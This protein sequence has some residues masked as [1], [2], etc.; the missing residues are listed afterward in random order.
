MFQKRILI[1]ED[2]V[3]IREMLRM[4]LKKEGFEVLEA[5]DGAVGW[6]KAAAEKPD[7]IL[8]DLMLPIMSGL[9]M[10]RKLR[11]HPPTAQLPALIVSARGE[12]SDV[13]VGLELGAD[14]YVTKPFNMSV[15]VARIN[16]L[17]RRSYAV[18]A[19]TSDSLQWGPLE[20]D[21][22]RFQVALD[23]KP[24]AL[25]RTE[26]GILYALTAAA[27]RVLTRNRLIE[28]AIGPE[29]IVVGRTIDVHLAS[30]RN[31]LGS[32]REMIET[33]RG[34]GYRMRFPDEARG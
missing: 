25:T 18:D 33:V 8:L 5:A 24:L 3:D 10:L 4:R 31:K 1:V 32:A 17:L 19:P 13:I 28:E 34:I 27:G 15:L 21:V 16:A 20:I 23:G 26:F 22:E 9:E 29:A 2:E 7:L 14:D 11:E 12:E 30:L 6:K